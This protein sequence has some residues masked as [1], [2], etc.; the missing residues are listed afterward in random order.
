MKIAHKMTTR[1]MMVKVNLTMKTKLFTVTLSALLALMMGVTPSHAHD[2]LPAEVQSRALL[3]TNATLHTAID[4]VK[5]NGDLLVEA[6]KITAIGQNI[7]APE[8]S[9]I[10]ATGKHIYPGLIALDTSLGLVEVEMMRASNDSYEVG[11][12][13]PQLE[14]ITA[15]NPDSEIIPTIRVNGITHAQVVPRGDSLAGQ[16]SVV[17]LDSWTI[18]DALVPSTQTFHLYW[19]KLT[20]LSHDAEKRQQ[21][22]DTYNEQVTDVSEAFS[23]GFRYFLANQAN[24][25][26]K[27]DLRWDAL[28]PLYQAKA[29][30]FVHAE[31]QKQI[32][33]A[34]SLAKQYQFKLVIVGGYDAWRLADLLNEIDAKVVYTHTL[35]LPMRKDEPIDL[36]FKIPSLLKQ[37]GIP[38]SLGFSSD[39]NSRNLPLAAGQTVAYGLTKQDA[40]KSVSL[41]A[42]RILGINDMGAIAV[43]YRAHLVVSNGDILDP[44]ETKIEQVY[45]DGRAID[46]NNRQ[47][48]L[49]QKYLKR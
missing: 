42:A 36:S 21:Q 27:V 29:Q 47:Q 6:G 45:I 17:S 13:N 40:L 32:E 41:D 38:F 2:M 20:R 16:S 43:G 22:I 24:K 18:E 34:A 31:T 39:W 7:I 35:S 11:H 1:K 4:G 5:T 48:Q 26:T 14:A 33:E 12:S 3:F 23:D 46:L 37:A 28:L 10:D 49:Y 9:H 8:A 44:M 25:S 30:L 19:P 15:F